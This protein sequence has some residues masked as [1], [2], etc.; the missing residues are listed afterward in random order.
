M[1]FEYIF[2]IKGHS[3]DFSWRVHDN[4]VVRAGFENGTTEKFM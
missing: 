3:L 4:H 2:S 1:G